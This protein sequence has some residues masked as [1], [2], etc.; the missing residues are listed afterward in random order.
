MARYRA[1]IIAMSCALAFAQSQRDS[2]ALLTTGTFHSDEVKARSGERWIGLLHGPSGFVW[3]AVT[4]A[5]HPVNDPVVD[6]PGEKTGIEVSVPGRAI[7]LTKGIPGLLGTKV[8]TV[9]DNPE[10]LILPEQDALELALNGGGYRIRVS[11]RRPGDDAPEKPSRLVL[12][13]AGKSQVLYEWP[14]GLLDQHCELLWAGDLDGDGKLDLVMILSDHYNVM[15]T[16]LFL[17]SRHSKGDL[18]KRIGKFVT[19]GC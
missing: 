16:T 10:G 3:R 7:L 11:D 6:E 5:A 13:S 18:V 15:E 14:T 4:I 19:T 17:S 2:I 12:E 8:R 1:V 9:L